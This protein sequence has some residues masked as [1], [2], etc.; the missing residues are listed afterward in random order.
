M[1]GHLRDQKTLASCAQKADSERH[2]D[3]DRQTDTHTQTHTDS[4]RQTDIHTNTDRHTHTHTQT[5]RHTHTDR[6]AKF[7]NPIL[8][9]GRHASFDLLLSIPSGITNK[10]AHFFHLYSLLIPSRLYSPT[11]H[12]LKPPVSCEILHTCTKNMVQKDHKAFNVR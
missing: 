10:P 9:S 5:D 12:F 4:H 1:H 6:P 2:R 7:Q 11:P 8:W 3:T